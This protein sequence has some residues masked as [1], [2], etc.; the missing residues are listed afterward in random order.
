MI[1]RGWLSHRIT[2]LSGVPKQQRV[3]L[4]NGHSYKTCC[5]LG[6]LIFQPHLLG[7]SLCHIFTSMSTY[8]CWWKVDSLHANANKMTAHED[9]SRGSA[10]LFKKRQ[11][12]VNESPI[13]PDDIFLS[14]YDGWICDEINAEHYKRDTFSL[15]SKNKTDKIRVQLYTNHSCSRTFGSVC[16]EQTGIE[17]HHYHCT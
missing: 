4:S 8:T 17:L 11:V 16:S 6:G 9:V 2:T 10:S 7:T 3:S 13:L 12:Y 5:E 14:L 15:S 1:A